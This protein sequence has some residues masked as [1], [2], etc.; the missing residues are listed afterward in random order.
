MGG[1]WHR[2][3]S[4]DTTSDYQRL[5]VRDW[6]RKGLLVRFAPTFFCD[7][8]K[9]DVVLP[10]DA[11]PDQE[12]IILSRLDR[13]S[14]ICCVRLDWT[15]CH[16]GGR[17]A[18]LLCPVSN[19]GRRVAI[20]YAHSVDNTIACRHCRNLAYESQR[21]PARYR[22]LHRAQKIRIKLGGSGSLA[23]PFPPKPSGMH[24]RTY[25]LNLLKLEE[26]EGRFVADFGRL[27]ERLRRAK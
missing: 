18:W 23:D 24:R 21:K 19:C 9:V 11:R 22:G 12:L 25:F 4:K 5:D 20:L 7:G 27:M 16:Y 15:P 1:S 3:D 2:W 6:Q 26:H 17:R 10:R 13:P 8:W 14:H